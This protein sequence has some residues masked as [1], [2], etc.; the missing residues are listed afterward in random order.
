MEHLGLSWLKANQTQK[1]C[2][3]G[4]DSMGPWDIM[5]YTKGEK[6]LIFLPN[7][8]THKLQHWLACQGIPK[9]AVSGAHVF[10]GDQEL[11]TYT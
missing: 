7:S 2:S 11:S 9:G 1:L 6:Q 4:L 3:W 8:D 10:S 5:Q